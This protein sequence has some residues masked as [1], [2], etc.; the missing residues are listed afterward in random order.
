MHLLPLSRPCGPVCD[1]IDEAFAKLKKFDRDD[2]RA[3]AISNLITEMMALD[4]Q[5]F[6]LVEDKGFCRLLR[7]LEPRFIIPG[8][9]HFAE[10]CLQAK[11]DETALLLHTLID[12]DARHMSFTTDIWTCDVNPVSMLG[13]TAQWLDKDFKLYRAVLH[14]Q[15]L[16]G[17]HTADMIHLAF[18][19]MLKK[20]NITK[21][22]VHVVLRA[23]LVILL[24]KSN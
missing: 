4:D 14:S 13:L 20:W 10:E 19:A 8:R 6:S 2:P 1:T 3:Q 18:V 23:V 9:R 22:M 17:S 16:P 24:K 15:E 7:H 5:P 11:Y 21:E 12:N